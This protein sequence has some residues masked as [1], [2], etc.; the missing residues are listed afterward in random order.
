MGSPTDPPTP[1][2]PKKNCPVVGLVR[3]DEHALRVADGGVHLLDGGR[4]TKARAVQAV[5]LVTAV[6][7][8]AAREERHVGTP[9]ALEVGPPP[10]QGGLLVED[11]APRVGEDPRGGVGDQRIVRPVQSGVERDGV[12][13]RVERQHAAWVVGPVLHFPVESR[14]ELG[15]GLEEVHLAAGPGSRGGPPHGRRVETRSV[16]IPVDLPP[17]V[18]ERIDRPLA[19]A[20]RVVVAERVGPGLRE[21]GR[22]GRSEREHPSID[23][24]HGRALEDPR[25]AVP[26]LVGRVLGADLVVLPD[27]RHEDRVVPRPVLAPDHLGLAVHGGHPDGLA[28]APLPHLVVEEVV[29]H[30]LREVVRA[31]GIDVHVDEHA[32]HDHA[33]VGREQ[34][35]PLAVRG[36]ERPAVEAGRPC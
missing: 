26:G 28:V 21:V 13:E 23:L 7:E 6:R 10:G 1:G 14:S 3:G 12:A 15:A 17:H 36:E 34:E 24:V 18:E 25:V 11:V 19:R 31:R 30:G 32:L 2:S 5:A 27:P 16:R 9:E 33:T 8:E 20:G 35:Q 29:D 4:D 22:V